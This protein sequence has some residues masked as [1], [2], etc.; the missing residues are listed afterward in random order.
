MYQA[1]CTLMLSQQLPE[2]GIH[3]SGIFGVNCR[4]GVVLSAVVKDEL[5]VVHK[6]IKS[7]VFVQVNLQLNSF[8]IYQHIV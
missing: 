2:E 8:E 1:S 6:R 7:L 4:F 5:H 3:M